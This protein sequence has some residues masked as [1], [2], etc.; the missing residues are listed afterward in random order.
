MKNIF[1]NTITNNLKHIIADI[2]INS[3]INE[4][5]KRQNFIDKSEN[6]TDKFN[7]LIDF[8]VTN[9]LIKEK[10][11]LPFKLLIEK[12]KNFR[13]R[14][15]NLVVFFNKPLK[16]KQKDVCIYLIRDVLT[17]YKAFTPN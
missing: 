17:E 12:N 9:K 13:K 7:W 3:M 8:I 15:S 2:T 4:V 1:Y 10:D 16:H 11:I 6:P 5:K 14:I